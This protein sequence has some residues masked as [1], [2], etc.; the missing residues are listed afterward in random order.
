MSEETKSTSQEVIAIMTEELRQ[1]E[2]LL[3]WVKRN[4][5]RLDALSVQPKFWEGQLDFD[6]LPHAEIL[7]VMKSFPCGK[8]NKELMGERVNYVG[9]YDGMTIRCWA[10][11]AP[12]SCK[13]VEEKVLIPERWETVRRLVCPQGESA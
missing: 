5:E 10:G 6:C 7:L 12:P 11:E 13:I 2:A 1:R 8:W 3:D 9:Q 4:A